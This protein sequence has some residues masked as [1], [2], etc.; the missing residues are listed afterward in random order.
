MQ[1]NSRKDFVEA[2]ARGLEVIR[3]FDRLHIQQTISQ[4]SERTLL[5]RP[6]VLRLLI[7]LD[8]LGY[9][10]CQDNRY[11][12]TPKV[13]DLGM[14][15]VSSLGLYG[16]AKPHMENLSK[17]V[18]QTVSLAE[19]DG[20]DI[21]YTG[22]VEVPK[23]VSVGVTVGSRLPSSSTALGR[24]LLA[25][26]PDTELHD[27]LNTPSLSMY[28]PRKRLTADQ[29]RPRLQTV[30][31]QGWAESDEDLQ[32]GVQA[33]AAPLRGEDGRVIAA[34]G[35]ATH[36]SEIGKEIVRE[37]YL[38]L[39]L[40]T[41]RSIETDWSECRKLPTSESALNMDGMH[42]LHLRRNSA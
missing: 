42:L 17:K 1:E 41:A 3:S 7:T 10:R 30:R 26:I 38:P 11:S 15:Y 27:V 36:T 25:E 21:V 31:E 22:R 9:V 34:I 35:L 13:V 6:T 40:E 28:V 12:L 39:L 2:L 20:S 16:A 24:V 5:A 32:Y 4:I 29:I 18:D 19:L 8:E 23:I 37:R 14:A 33:I